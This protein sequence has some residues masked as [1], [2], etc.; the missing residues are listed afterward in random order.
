[1][2]MHPSSNIIYT[3]HLSAWSMHMYDMRCIN[4]HIHNCC[5]SL[6]A[7]WFAVLLPFLLLF[8]VCTAALPVFFCR[9]AGRHFITAAHVID[10]H[11]PES[12]I[13]N[14]HHQMAISRELHV[15]NM[16]MPCVKVCCMYV[17]S[18]PRY[19]MW[20]V[21]LFL[22]FVSLLAFFL[23]VLLIILN[24]FEIWT[25]RLCVRYI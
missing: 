3:A 9:Y 5:Y 15:V 14:T 22:C 11:P 18:W 7:C 20:V 8:S 21:V 17:C 6:C 10:C 24:S 4:A 25:R 2:H 19:M 12:A 13:T 23:V 1:M 16:S